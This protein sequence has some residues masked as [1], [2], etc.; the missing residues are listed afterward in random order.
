MRRR[1]RNRGD[2]PVRKVYSGS[3]I[4]SSTDR[5]C[6]VIVDYKLP[7][8]GCRDKIEAR[9]L[10]AIF[11]RDASYELVTPLMSMGCFCARDL[12][13]QF[14]K[15]SILEFD[16]GNSLDAGVSEAGNRAAKGA[17]EHLDSLRYEMDR[18]TLTIA[19]RDLRKSLRE[20]KGWKVAEKPVE[21]LLGSKQVH[22]TLSSGG[23]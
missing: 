14:W 21:K 3:G 1:W 10:L 22:T 11:N 17:T 7:W 15:L 12:H 16:A 9:Y 8:T 6:R 19:R 4:R 20:S 23:S 5:R 13:K 2:R 18:A